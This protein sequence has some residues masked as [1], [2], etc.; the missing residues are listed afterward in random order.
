VNESAVEFLTSH[1]NT[2]GV[3]HSGRNL[4][5]H[6]SGTYQL[7]K[8]WG[9]SESTC[10]AGLYHSIYG[11]WHF[12]RKSFPIAN[13]GTIAALIGSH[14]E[15]LVYLF[16]VTRRPEAF[17]KAYQGKHS[18]FAR[19]EDYSIR[20][21]IPIT[22]SELIS[23]LEIEAANL[24]EQ[25][26]NITGYLRSLLQTSISGGA[27]AAL[28]NYLSVSEQYVPIPPHVGGQPTA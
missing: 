7:L 15:R 23:L 16:C 6:L 17:F 26:G 22:E 9:N 13:R 14:A 12:R 28:S 27:K 24:L 10:L 11:T 8:S 4:F 3:R 1:L 18:G 25:E 19:L 2:Q 20:A 21:I 5:I